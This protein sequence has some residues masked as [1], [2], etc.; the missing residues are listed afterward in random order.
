MDFSDL[1]LI[2]ASSSAAERPAR[3]MQIIRGYT[4]A[5]FDRTL[6]GLPA[7]FLEGRGADV[8]SVEFFPPP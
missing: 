5:F 4:R 1:P 3:V 8:Q 7:P 2:A 6:K